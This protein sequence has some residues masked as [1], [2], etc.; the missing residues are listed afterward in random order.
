[1]SANYAIEPIERAGY[2][3]V[4][5]YDGRRGLRA[6]I[7]LWAGDFET[8]RILDRVTGKPVERRCIAHVEPEGSGFTYALHVGAKGGW[9]YGW[10]KTYEQALD[11][12]DQWA[13]RRLTRTSEA[14]R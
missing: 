4:E 3:V 5:R 6:C 12:I 14:A 10:A 13:R 9:R 11:A 7:D 1:M 8:G 2:E